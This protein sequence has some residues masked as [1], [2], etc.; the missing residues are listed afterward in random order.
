MK[1]LLNLSFSLSAI[2]IEFFGLLSIILLDT[3]NIFFSNSLI[4]LAFSF[5]FSFSYFF[6]SEFS[7][8]K[9][10]NSSF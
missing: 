7:F 8:S 4:L 1:T 3:S 10:S 9:N 2:E 6:H 5:S